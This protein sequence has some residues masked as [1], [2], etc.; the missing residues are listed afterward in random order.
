MGMIKEGKHT[1]KQT[2]GKIVLHSGYREIIDSFY[3]ESK[4]LTNN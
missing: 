2:D 3:G 1:V 4:H